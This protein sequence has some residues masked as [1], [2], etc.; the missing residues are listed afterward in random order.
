MVEVAQLRCFAE[1][2]TVVEVNEASWIPRARRP[3][4][5]ACGVLGETRCGDKMSEVV[6]FV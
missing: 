4:G 3:L 5:A 6:Q 2:R 1:Y